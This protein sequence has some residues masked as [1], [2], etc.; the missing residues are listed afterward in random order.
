M[1]VGRILPVIA[2][3]LLGVAV[4]PATGVS[5]VDIP[6]GAL[7]FS[8]NV[9]PPSADQIKPSCD[10]TPTQI[11][12]EILGGA[13]SV[14]LTCTVTNPNQVMTGTASNATLAAQ[15]AGFNSGTMSA[16]CNAQQKFTTTL[17]VT[18]SGTSTSVVMSSLSGTVLQACS[19]SLKFADAQQSS[20]AGTI[21]LNATVASDP[22]SFATSRVISFAFTA[23][24]FVT[25]GTGAFTGLVGNGEFSQSQS[26]DLSSSVPPTTGGGTPAGSQP[27][28]PSNPEEF[29]RLNPSQCTFQQSVNQSVRTAGV[30][31]MATPSKM[32][33]TLAKPKKGGVVRI[34]SP[35][36]PVGQAKGSAAVTAKS[37]VSLVATPKS[38]CTVKTNTGKVVGKGTVK[39][40][41]LL[42][43]KPASNAYTGAKSIKATCTLNKKTFSSSAVK[44]ALKK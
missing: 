2:L 42:N 29:C 35:T 6:V 39:A 15:D 20:L 38:V 21:E 17:S 1:R 5:A 26:I 4:A 43:I 40:S 18:G 16:N 8:I 9:D 37:K 25:T 31:T 32:T 11:G 24:V 34:V 22:S 23:K 19:F 12:S 41:G 30:R 10:K 14:T 3:S 44:V 33:L 28:L 7:D 36:A 27:E 13:T